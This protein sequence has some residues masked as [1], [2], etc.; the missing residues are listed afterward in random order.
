MP[1]HETYR[2]ITVDE[3]IH[4]RPDIPSDYHCRCN[5]CTDNFLG[6]I[7]HTEKDAYYSQSTRKQYY[8]PKVKPEGGFDKHICPGH[9][10]GYRYAI[11]QFT[12][13]GD[14]VFDPTVGT[15]TAIVEAINNGR[16]G[17]GI[18]LEYSHITQRSVDVQY[19][20]ETAKAKG[21]VISGNAEDLIELLEE[22]QYHGECFDLVING[23]PYP[24]LGGRQSDAPE[25]A[26]T[27][28]GNEYKK[29]K[30]IQYKKERGIGTKGKQDYWD[31]I[32]KLYKDSISKLKPGGKFVT[33][34][35]DPTQNK[36][37][38]LLHKFIMDLV[39][40]TNPV[41]YY[42]SFVHRHM[43]YTLF[44]NTYPKQNPDAD[45]IPVFQTGIVFEK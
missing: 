14:T 22:R 40:E 4:S 39:L 24:V 28:E 10:Q 30:L 7:Y 35:K 17:V 29:S 33:I 6:E 3:Q 37:P 34:I 23:S 9:W 45:P 27:R 36:K 8:F 5:L 41:K 20:N 25:R 21:E 38:Y 44:M 26:L 11:Q 42:G 18:E 43:P 16:N 19:D 13:P 1:N 2:N 31:M 15:G 12:K 32:E